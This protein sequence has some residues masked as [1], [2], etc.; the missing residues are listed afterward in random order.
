M[1]GGKA[2]RMTILEKRKRLLA[3]IQTQWRIE[4]PHDYTADTNPW[5]SR[6]N[7]DKRDDILRRLT[8]EDNKKPKDLDK[9]N[10][11]Y[12]ELMDLTKLPTRKEAIIR[13]RRAF[14]YIITPAWVA[15]ATLR[16][17][18][19]PDLDDMIVGNNRQVIVSSGDAELAVT[20][21]GTSVERGLDTFEVMLKYFQHQTEAML[22]DFI[23]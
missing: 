1:A 18:G 4:T 23:N 13:L 8:I 9:L 15:D 3:S 5:D 10:E 11:L 6:E 2:R 22:E 12:D 20:M 19:R 16:K 7:C 17:M 21:H 14:A